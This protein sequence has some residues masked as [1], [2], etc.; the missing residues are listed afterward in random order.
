MR[1]LSLKGQ[2]SERE[3]FTML[4]ALRNWQ[5]RLSELGATGTTTPSELW[6]IIEDAMPWFGEYFEEGDEPLTLSEIDALCERINFA[7]K[8][9]K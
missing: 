3:C 2:L 8:E 5:E 7:E 6:T 4:A 9:E 1:K